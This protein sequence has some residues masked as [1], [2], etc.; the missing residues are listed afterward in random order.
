MNM[1][2]VAEEL[3]TEVKSLRKEVDT[4]KQ[5]KGPSFGERFNGKAP[6]GRSGESALT[7]RGYSFVKMIEAV[8]TKNW[9]KAKVEADLHNRLQESYKN[10]LGFEKAASN[11]ILCPVSHA[12]IAEDVKDKTLALECRD[13]VQAGISGYDPE[14]VAHYRQKYWGREKALS[15]VDESLGG[16]L[17]APPMQGELIEIL[18]N[19]EAL[20]AAGCRVLGMPPQGRITYPRQTGV[21]TGYWVGE[22]TSITDSTQGTGDLVLQAKKLG[23]LCKIPNELFR[24][25]S[26]SIEQFV[27]DDIARVMALTLDKALLEGN[28]G[29]STQPKGL[30][31][32]SNINLLSAAVTGANGD[33]FQ[34]EDVAN[35]VQSVEEKNAEFK[36]FIMRPLMFAKITNRRADAAVAGDQKG[37]F[38]FNW[39]RDF[40]AQNFGLGRMQPANIYGYPAIKSTQ[41]SNT[42][43]KGNATNLTYI[44]GGD[45]NDFLLAM[46]GV[47]EFLIA[48]QGDTAVASDQTW[49]RG[50]QYVDGGPRHEASFTLMDTLLQA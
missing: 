30:I 21:A 32:Y 12:L 4:L 43:T 41:L 31:T 2:S 44:L 27:R 29:G 16:A 13:L 18:R 25:A 8:I 37:G 9:D 33:T 48:T 1:G 36:A 20:M 39:M 19:N 5:R 40:N 47:I 23:V 26:V 22:S 50:I 28:T 6:A 45:F 17:V 24:F 34:P 10:Q 42:R 49:V 46:G 14:E 11:S 38:M 3:L 7:S 35:F 15:W